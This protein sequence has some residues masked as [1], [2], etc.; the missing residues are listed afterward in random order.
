MDNSEQIRINKIINRLGE[1]G[2]N[3]GKPLS[4]LDYFREKY[5]NS[6]RIYFLVYNE[7]SVILVV[8]ISDKKTQQATINEIIRNLEDYKHYVLKNLRG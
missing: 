6:K 8:G 3:I 5:L 7:L 2:D 1:Q 4:G